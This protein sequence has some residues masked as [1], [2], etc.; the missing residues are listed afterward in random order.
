MRSADRGRAPAGRRS[1]EW[2]RGR[3]VRTWRSKL[4]RRPWRPAGARTTGSSSRSSTTA[5]GCPRCSWVGVVRL[6]DV[7]VRVVPKLAGGDLG[8]AA[9]ARLRERARRAPDARRGPHSSRLRAR[10]L[11]DLIWLAARG[12]CRSRIVRPACSR[13]TCSRDD[14]AARA[15]RSPAGA[16]S[17][18]RR[19]TGDRPLE[20]A[21]DELETDI[22]ENQIL[23]AALG[24]RTSSL[25]V[26]E[27]CATDRAPATGPRRGVRRLV[28][29][30][31]VGSSRARRPPAQRALPPGP[32]NRVAVPHPIGRR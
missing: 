18:A 7:E 8:V 2:Q 21:F 30:P 16:R 17:G 20:C 15:A 25:L 19:A 10:S 28:A 27:V 12:C 9:H 32:R 6:R 29:R 22:A 1:T 4:T 13:T 23:A 3:I 14:D 31:G 11:V 24:D 5:S 26:S